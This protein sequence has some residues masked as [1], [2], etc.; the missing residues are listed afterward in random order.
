MSD[1]TCQE[2]FEKRI[3][4][5]LA[6]KPELPKKINEAFQFKLTGDGGGDWYIDLT[7]ES[8][9]TAAG[10]KAD[11]GVTVTMTATDFIALVEGTLN[12]QMAFMSGKL[13]V[14]GNM[15]LALKLQEILN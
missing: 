1:L 11:A 4:E 7:K 8:D 12:P 2:I 10:E 3:P 15:A 9:F 13:K 6:K 5:R 14:S